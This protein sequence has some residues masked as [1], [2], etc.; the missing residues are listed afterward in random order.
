M[1][2]DEGAFGVCC[3]GTLAC[4]VLNVPVVCCLGTLAC[5]VIRVPVCGELLGYISML[6]G[7][8]PVVNY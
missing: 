2:C 6:C 7:E 5:P 1:P 8:V 4:P 3:L